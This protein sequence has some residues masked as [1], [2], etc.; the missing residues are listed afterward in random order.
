MAGGGDEAAR[1]ATGGGAGGASARGSDAVTDA[2]RAGRA[3]AG[4]ATQVRAVFAAA[5]ADAGAATKRARRSSVV[6]RRLL[7]AR[8]RVEAVRLAKR[9]RGEEPLTARRVRRATFTVYGGYERMVASRRHAQEDAALVV[10][11]AR[12]RAEAAAELE[13]EERR[14]RRRRRAESVEEVV[15]RR[16]VGEIDMGWLTPGWAASW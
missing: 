4:E 3:G 16:G 6:E 7:A 14:E 11:G 10:A 5:G 15:A 13:A 2:G 8:Q 1:A 9:L 12:E